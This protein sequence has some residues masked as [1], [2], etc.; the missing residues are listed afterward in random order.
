MAGDVSLTF[1]E[2][3][4][5]SLRSSLGR[6]FRHASNV[7]DGLVPVALIWLLAIV[8]LVAIPTATCAAFY[9]A[10]RTDELAGPPGK[11]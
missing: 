6:L 10:L 2:A 9:V 5:Q 3:R 7:T 1:F 8:A 4:P 11:G